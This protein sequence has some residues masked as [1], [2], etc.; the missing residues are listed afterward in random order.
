[1]ARLDF[2]VTSSKTRLWHEDK[3]LSVLDRG[4]RL[5]QIQGAGV[6][7]DSLSMEAGAQT[8]GAEVWSC[9][10]RSLHCNSGAV[11]M[12]RRRPG[13]FPRSLPGAG[14]VPGST[15]LHWHQRSHLAKTTAAL[16]LKLAHECVAAASLP[17][18]KISRFHL[19]DATLCGHSCPWATT[20]GHNDLHHCPRRYDH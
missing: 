13:S 19:F 17:F 2:A 20:R 11:R 14:Q 3:E 9:G 7:H 18:F 10:I 6:G 12:T 4:A 15:H 1:M 5:R 8:R 16:P